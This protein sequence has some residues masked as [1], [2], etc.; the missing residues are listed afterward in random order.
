MIMRR[1]CRILFCFAF[2]VPLI[3]WVLA[4]VLIAAIGNICICINRREIRAQQWVVDF[5]YLP[6]ARSICSDDD[7]GRDA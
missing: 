7:Y 2:N 5:V 4:S 1:I 3:P 6:I